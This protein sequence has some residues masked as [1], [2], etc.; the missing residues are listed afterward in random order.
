MNVQRLLFTVATISVTLVA[1]PACKEGVNAVRAASRLAS[2]ARS[3][4]DE[5]ISSNPALNALQVAAIDACNAGTA[6]AKERE[7]EADPELAVE[8]GEFFEQMG[9][10]CDGA[11]TVVLYAQ[12]GGSACVS[13]LTAQLSCQAAQACPPSEDEAARCDA[14]RETATTTCEKGF[15]FE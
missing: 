4:N 1:S 8:R 12:L 13:A 2:A 7:N 9:Q 5:G 11:K 15:S 14:L 6:C 3:L 10:A